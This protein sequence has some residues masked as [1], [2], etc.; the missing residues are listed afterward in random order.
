MSVGFD[1]S[2]DGLALIDRGFVGDD[3]VEGLTL[4][5]FG[6]LWPDDA[7][8]IL[9]EDPITTTWTEQNQG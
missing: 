9:C 2:I 5:T 7:I 1:A 8:W 3:N 4:N 6:F